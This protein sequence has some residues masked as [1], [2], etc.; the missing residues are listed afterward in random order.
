MKFLQRFHKE[1]NVKAINILNNI[2]SRETSASFRELFL[3]VSRLV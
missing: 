1:Q 3:I 2:L